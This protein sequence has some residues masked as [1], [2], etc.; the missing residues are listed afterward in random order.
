MPS[1]ATLIRAWALMMALTAL[2][3]WAAV[4]DQGFAP[5]VAAMAAGVLKAVLILWVYLNLRRSGPGWKAVFIAF[6]LVIALIVLGA[7]GVGLFLV[8]RGNP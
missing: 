3:I 7:Y 4:S 6:L 8:T 1:T 2:S 5:T